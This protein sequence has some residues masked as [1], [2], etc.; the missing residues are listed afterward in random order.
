MKTLSG[1]GK[2]YGVRELRRGNVVHC[3]LT[4]GLQRVLL[5][6]PLPPPWRILRLAGLLPSPSHSGICISEK[7]IVAVD[8]EG[9]AVVQTPKEFL[10]G[11]ARGIYVACI[12]GKSLSFPSAADSAEKRVGRRYAYNLLRN[13][14]HKF[15][16]MCLRGDFMGEYK[17]SYGEKQRFSLS[18]VGRKKFLLA[19]VVKAVQSKRHVSG[20]VK[21]RV[22]QQRIR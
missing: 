17:M 8:F 19:D 1:E 15:S 12:N 3:D 4:G 10:F 7:E 16:C 18:D 9:R 11:F 22:L 2:K 21:W 13:N 20:R 6:L 5:G 14:C